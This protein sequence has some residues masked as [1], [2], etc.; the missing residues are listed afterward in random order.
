METAAEILG[1]RAVRAA[2]A[3][4]KRRIEIDAVR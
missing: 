2:A 4:P 3:A 1:R